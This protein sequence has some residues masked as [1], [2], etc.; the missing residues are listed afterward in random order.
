MARAY[1][2]HARG[3]SGIYRSVRNFTMVNEAFKFMV[4]KVFKFFIS[5]IK[6]T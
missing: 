2:T 6:T 4:N 1:Q 5:G 3:A